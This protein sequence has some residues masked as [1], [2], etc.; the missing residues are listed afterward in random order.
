MKN[1]AGRREKYGA[2]SILLKELKDEDPVAY[3][4]ILGLGGAQLDALL[5]MIDGMIKKQDTKMRMAIQTA[6]KLEIALPYLAT[7]NSFK[8]SE[9]LF[10]V[11]EPTISLFVP[12]VLTAFS[13]ILKPFIKVSENKVIMN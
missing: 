6:T 9:Y 12:E 3:R 7:G 2:T 13:H 10:R 11:P 8:S 1:W 4:N 5:Q